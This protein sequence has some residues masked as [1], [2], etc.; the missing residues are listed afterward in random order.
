MWGPTAEALNASEPQDRNCP[1][2]LCQKVLGSEPGPRLALA[3]V[4][5]RIPSENT[6]GGF[7]EEVLRGHRASSRL[8][9]LFH[10]GQRVAL[11]SSLK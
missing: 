8:E 6:W 1:P 11:P 4:I 2:C 9:A 7:P 3:L 10:G 5:A